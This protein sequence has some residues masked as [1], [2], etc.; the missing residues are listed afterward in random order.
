[1]SAESV[2]RTSTDIC[3]I[4]DCQIAIRYMYYVRLL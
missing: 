1:M 3:Y 2:Y 4:H